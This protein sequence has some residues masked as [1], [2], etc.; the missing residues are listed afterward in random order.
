MRKLLVLVS[1]PLLAAAPVRVK[2]IQA[3][4]TWGAGVE[5]KGTMPTGH[6]EAQMLLTGRNVPQKPVFRVWRVKIGDFPGLDSGKG[7]LPAMRKASR[8]DVLAIPST[9]GTW[10]IQGVWASAPESNDRLVVE[11]LAGARHLGWA[12][13][14]VSEQF[15]QGFEKRPITGREE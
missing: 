5:P 8:L 13:A 14:A 15:L 2:V 9:G 6:F 1:L 3:A 11:V 4:V 10:V 12:C 7:K